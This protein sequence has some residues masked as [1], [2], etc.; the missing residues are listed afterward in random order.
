MKNIKITNQDL[1]NSKSVDVNLDS[2]SINTYDGRFVAKGNVHIQYGD[3]EYQC[4]CG[5]HGQYDFEEDFGFI[6]VAT[7]EN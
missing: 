7:E 1:F 4:W 3:K 5:E 6:L 2:L